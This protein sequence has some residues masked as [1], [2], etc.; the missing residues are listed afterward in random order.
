MMKQQGEYELQVDK[1]QNTLMKIKQNRDEE[2]LREEVVRV[3]EERQ[4]LLR[5]SAIQQQKIEQFQEEAN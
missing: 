2:S 5:K 4:A 1:L 3:K